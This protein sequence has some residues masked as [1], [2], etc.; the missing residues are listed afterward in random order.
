MQ[1]SRKI[2]I[3]EDLI[4]RLDNRILPIGICQILKWLKENEKITDY[5]Y[6]LMIQFFNYSTGYYDYLGN[7]VEK[8]DGAFRFKNNEKRLKYL[9]KKLKELQCKAETNGLTLE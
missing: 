3:I 5:E 9:N 2:E 8:C 1:S 7:I 6:Y 4:N